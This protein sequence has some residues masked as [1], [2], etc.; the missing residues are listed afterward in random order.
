MLVKYNKGAIPEAT[1]E[2]ELSRLCEETKNN[3]IESF[4]SYQIAD[5]CS[6]IIKLVDT[7]NKYINDNEPWAKQKPLKLWVNV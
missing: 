6:H 7:A 3:I 1:G 2:N 5:A 4:N